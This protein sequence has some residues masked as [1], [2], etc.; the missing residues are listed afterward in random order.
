MWLIVSSLLPTSAIWLRLVYSY[1][2]IV[3]PYGVF[4]FFF[5][6]AAI[7]RDSVSLLKFPFLSYIQVFSSDISVVC[8]L[9]YPYNCFYFYFCFLVI[10][11]SIDSCVIYIVSG[12]FNVFF[13]VF[14]CIFLVF[15]SIHRRYLQCWRVLFFLLFL[16]HTLC[17]HRHWDFSG[18]FVEGFP[19][20]TSKM[21]L[22][23]LQGRQPRHLFLGW[24]FCYIVWFKVVFLF[25]W[26]T[27]FYFFLS[28]P[29]V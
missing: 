26:D 17:L 8:R 10:F 18:L 14:L 12:C 19:S 28:S 1:F 24:D 6:F 25:S 2:D 3:C 11:C 20:P 13:C 15:I 9:K 7:R 21:V 5:F 4:F 23:I 16:T 27:L 29:L 22:G